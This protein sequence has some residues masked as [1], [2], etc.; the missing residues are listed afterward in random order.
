RVVPAD[1]PAADLEPGDARDV[2]GRY[3]PYLSEMGA[4]AVLVRPDFYVFGIAG[5]KA[6]LPSLVDDLAKQL[7]PTATPS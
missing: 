2:E 4:L 3:L 1:T 5:D 7:T 6:E